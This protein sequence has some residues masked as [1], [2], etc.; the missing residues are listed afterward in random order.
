MKGLLIKDFKLMLNQ[1]N[2]FI[3]IVLILGATACFLDFDYYFLIGYFMFICSLFT[4]ST[5]SYD[6]FDNGNAFLFSLPITRKGYVIEKY[7]FGI[8][9]GVISLILSTII[10]CIL[11]LFLNSTVTNDL[12]LVALI[13]IPIVLV[14]Q[15]LMLPL[16]IKFG[17][18]KSRVAM[19]IV[20]AIIFIIG[21]GF[22]ELIRILNIDFTPFINTLLTM[23]VSMIL[24]I[25][26]ILSLIIMFISCKISMK[27]I[28]NKEF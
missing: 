27:I 28:K 12:F 26:M 19:F 9:L 10:A 24:V 25:V 18:E 21:Y 6:E 17:S 22:N 8:M 1:K 3:L 2:F 11:T 14:L 20:F 13:Y 7:I 23:N 16:Q 4:I 15:S 5:I